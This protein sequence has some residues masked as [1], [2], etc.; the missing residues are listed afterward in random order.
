MAKKGGRR[1]IQKRPREKCFVVGGGE[2]KNPRG[3]KKIGVGAQGK[4][5]TYDPK[6]K[7]PRGENGAPDHTHREEVGFKK[8]KKKPYRKGGVGGEPRRQ[9]SP[10]NVLPNRNRTQREKKKSC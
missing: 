8:R 3:E 6:K 1:E 4:T 9:R 7:H 2:K 10:S 5:G